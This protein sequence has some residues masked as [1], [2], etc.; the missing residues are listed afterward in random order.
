MDINPRYIHYLERVHTTVLIAIGVMPFV[1]IY[2]MATL[3]KEV[4]KQT[5]AQ[6]QTAAAPVFIARGKPEMANQAT[7]ED[8]K[9]FLDPCFPVDHR[10]RTLDKGCGKTLSIP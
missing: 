8:L 7:P 2:M 10:E 6:W 4:R 3:T 5:N 9:E 1:M